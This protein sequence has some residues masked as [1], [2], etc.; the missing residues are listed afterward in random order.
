MNKAFYALGR[1]KSGQMNKL[2]FWYSKVLEA[3]KSAGKIL[4]F[5][6]EAIKLRLADKTF[7]TPDF[8]VMLAN[9]EM[10]F[11]ETKGFITDDAN[12]KI[13]V[14]AS[15]FPFRFKLVKKGR[16]GALNI[17]EVGNNE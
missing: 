16:A 12:V 11:H 15:L 4:W 17:I 14:A 1:L 10:E 6:F 8:A 5:S 7:Y 9:F 3:E 2:E 13:K